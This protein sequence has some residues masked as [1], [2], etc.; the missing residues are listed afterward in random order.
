MTPR[1]LIL[2]SVQPVQI[3]VARLRRKRYRTQSPNTAVNASTDLT[4]CQDISAMDLGAGVDD[5]ESG[6]DEG[7]HLAAMTAIDME[8]AVGCEQTRSVV[9]FRETNQGRIGQ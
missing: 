2:Q 4:A 1:A 7:N 6:R 9:D 3:G 8:V 5:C